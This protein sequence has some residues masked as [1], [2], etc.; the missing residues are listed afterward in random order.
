MSLAA[1]KKRGGKVNQ[2]APPWEALGYLFLKF[3]S[4]KPGSFLRSDLCSTIWGSG[5]VSVDLAAAGEV[6]VSWGCAS[7]SLG[8]C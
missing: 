7:E 6:I 4:W 1:E 8:N 5:D 3:L 2:E